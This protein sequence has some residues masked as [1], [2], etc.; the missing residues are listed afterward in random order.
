[1]KI[2]DSHSHWLP[3]EIIECASFFHPAWSD[4]EGQLSAMDKAGIERSLLTYPTTDAHLKMQGGWS[5]VAR[6]FNDG[7]AEIIK[8]YP[9]RFIGAFILPVGEQ[10]LM[11]K[12]CRY[13]YQNL[14]LRVLSLASSYNGIYLDSEIF[15]SIYEYCWAEDIPIFVHSQITSPIGYERVKDPLLSPVIEYVFDLTMCAGK[16]MMSG[17][18]TDFGDLKFV[19]AHFAGVLP[20]IKERFDTTYKMLRGINF[21]RD[22]GTD[23]SKILSRIYF[24]TSG[25]KSP[26]VLQCAL[27]MT[28]AEHILFGSDWPANKNLQD[29]I[30][31]ILNSGLEETEKK[32]ILSGNFDKILRRMRK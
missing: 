14:G 3:R 16:I 27:E 21:V 31:I 9:D 32:R 24:D 29:S 1:M 17:V 20:F 6:V 7:V 8:K 26:S 23:P 12:E 13:A 25:C 11:D 28:A 10:D 18:L 19:F 22:L 30:E 4:I 2:C 5:K 15:F